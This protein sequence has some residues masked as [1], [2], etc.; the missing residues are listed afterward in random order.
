M[1]EGYY[2]M[3]FGYYLLSAAIGEEEIDGLLA[4]L[5]RA[6]HTLGLVAT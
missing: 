2:Q 3:S 4:A 1:N 5:E 6:L